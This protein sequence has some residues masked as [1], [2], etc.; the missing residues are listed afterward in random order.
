MGSVLNG[1]VRAAL[2]MVLG[3]CMSWFGVVGADDH[4]KLLKSRE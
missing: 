4:E 3:E 1:S 2:M